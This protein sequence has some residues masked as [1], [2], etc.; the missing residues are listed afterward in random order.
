[1]MISVLFIIVALVVAIMLIPNLVAISENRRASLS[2]YRHFQRTID[3]Y[4]RV[5]EMEMGTPMAEYFKGSTYLMLGQKRKARKDFMRAKNMGKKI[6]PKILE[7][8]N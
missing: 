5:I 1:M 6:S 7:M 8:C 2:N 4:S 3:E